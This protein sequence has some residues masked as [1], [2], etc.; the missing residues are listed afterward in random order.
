MKTPHSL[1]IGGTRGLGRAMA[2]KF[3]HQGHR[4]SVIARNLPT[5]KQPRR[6][7]I[8]AVDL[9]QQNVLR[10]SLKNI[11]KDGGRLTNLVFCQRYRGQGD[12][13]E[14]ELAVSLT[15]TRNVIDL[16]ADKFDRSS[17]GAVVVVSSIAAHA[18]TDSQP[19][20]YHVVKAGLSQLVR[21]YAYTLGPKNIRVNSVAPATFMKEESRAFYLGNKP[22]QS[23][24]RDIIPLGRMGT[25][26]DVANV[27]S[28]LCGP[29][30]SFL[31]GQTIV[32]DGGL[33]LLWPESLAR[34]LALGDET[35]GGKRR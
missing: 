4:V 17:G 6:V 3:A 21:Y 1:I 23:L 15:A 27:I 12:P 29:Q 31:T 18:I 8:T 13:W 10:S 28:F 35:P 22:L 33:S 30:A 19:L 34:R 2:R 25:T 7:H 5:G 24:Y 11:I 32:V 9:T 16:L 20:G 26:D 14:E